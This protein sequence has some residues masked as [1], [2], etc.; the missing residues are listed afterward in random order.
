MSIFSNCILC[1]SAKIRDL[2]LYAKHYLCK[3]RSCGFVFSKKNP[4]KKELND[5]YS[6]YSYTD[7]YYVSPITINRYKQILKSM[8]KYRS[9][10]RILDV[11]CGNG[12]FLSVAKELGWDCYGLEL[13]TAGV[14]YCKEKGLNAYEGILKEL[15]D[16]LPE[17]D[18]IVSIEVMEH[19]NNPN[20]ELA[21][22]YK[23]LRKGGAVYIT[24]P[25]F[26][27]L[28]RYLTKSNFDIVS[29]PGHLSYYT[30][31]TLKKAFKRNGFS[32][33]KV[34]TTG[35]SINRFL[36][37]SSKNKE[38][39][40]KAGSKDENC[41]NLWKANGIWGLPRKSQTEY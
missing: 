2:P 12:I 16:K 14:K 10:N 41:G 26:N 39:P 1:G 20:E 17:F 7:S 6:K 18:I 21:L 25:N 34:V 5:Y 29:Y 36:R 33:K 30:P 31:K 9:N 38:N 27:G 32:V 28:T 8:D 37:S 22:F 4:D 40:Y 19:I 11:G 24:T 35:F 15:Y 3:C 23:K 13:S